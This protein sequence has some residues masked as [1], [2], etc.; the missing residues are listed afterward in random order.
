MNREIQNLI[1]TT[2]VNITTHFTYR[3]QLSENEHRRYHRIHTT[4]NNN[5]VSG[6]IMGLSLG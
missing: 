1:I 6:N 2:N 3:L 5:T 4:G